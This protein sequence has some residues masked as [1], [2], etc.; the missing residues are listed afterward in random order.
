[1]QVRSYYFIIPISTMSFVPTYN[2]TYDQAI[3]NITLLQTNLFSI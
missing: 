1:M 2:M 3:D